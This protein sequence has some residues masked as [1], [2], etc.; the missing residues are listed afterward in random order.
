[1]TTEANMVVLMVE[2][3]EA[4]ETNMLEEKSQIIEIKKDIVIMACVVDGEQINHHK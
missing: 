4:Q 2:N 1:M 3:I